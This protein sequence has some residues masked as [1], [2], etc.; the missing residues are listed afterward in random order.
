MVRD[1]EKLES[2]LRDVYNSA[3]VEAKEN[4]AGSGVKYDIGVLENGNTYVIASRRIIT[5]NDLPTMRKQISGFFDALLEE[6]GSLDIPTIDG[7]VLTITKN[8]TA[9]KAR[10][11]Y[12]YVNGKRIKMSNSEYAVKARAGSHID[13]LA[14]ISKELPK[15]SD[16][17]KNHSFSKNGFTYRTA[18][19][20][21]F[22]G[23]YYQITLSIGNNASVATIY[24]IGKIK[25]DRLPSAK[26]IAVV[27]SKPHG[28][29]PSKHSIRQTS[30]KSQEDFSD[31]EKSS[32]RGGR[33]DELRY[34]P[35]MF[36]KWLLRKNGSKADVATVTEMIKKIIAADNKG[37]KT[38]DINSE[39]EYT[40]VSTVE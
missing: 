35:E 5:A 12:K 9:N 28:S 24:N 34:R 20:E 2:K 32:L 18:Y 29:V 19:F 13:E 33:L 14:E 4:T 22:D 25:E 6:K 21:D 8:E 30:E 36:A 1:L 10:D 17:K 3:Q 16:D 23:Q 37:G 38:W 7:D 27:G 15:S 40:K 31:N 39:G 11:N 26:L